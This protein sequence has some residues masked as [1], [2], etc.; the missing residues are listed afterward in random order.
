MRAFL[1]TFFR[2]AMKKTALTLALMAAAA[3]SFAQYAGPG[4]TPAPASVQA[5]LA[6]P[7]DD[8]HV[9]LRGKIVRQ[10]RGDK[11]I[12]SDGTGEIRVDIDGHLFPQGQPIAA[13]TTV[14]IVGEVDADVMETTEIDVDALRIVQ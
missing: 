8:Q 1:S 4:S 3:A 2:D 13:S 10:L 11:Y 6:H 5:I 14:E 12:F 9:T 7:V